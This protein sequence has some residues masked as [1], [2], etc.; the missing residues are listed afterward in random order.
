MKVLIISGS[1]RD[2]DT[3]K[4]FKLA[5][6][7]HAEALSQGH[8]SSIWNLAEKPLPIAEPSFHAD[9]LAEGNP[10]LVR[11]FASVVH[12][13][14]SIVLCTPTYHGSY[15]ALLKNALDCMA[16]D[17]FKGKTVVLASHGWSAT[18]MT[19]CTHLQDVV[20]TMQGNVYRRFFVAET[21]CL[22]TSQL[23]EKDAKR[24]KEILEDI[25]I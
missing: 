24:L 22:A 12:E 7:I 21:G 3:S 19:P 9:P 14:D 4:T 2:Q 13:S 25:S 18:A 11:E 8:K 1:P 16:E 5:S 20:R 15:S 23:A 10:E 6:I 17:Q